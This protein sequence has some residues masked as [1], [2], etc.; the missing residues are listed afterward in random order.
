VV[1]IGLF[2]EFSYP[3][4]TEHQMYREVMEQIVLADDLGYD[5]FSTTQSF[6]K[7]EVSCSSF[8]LGLYV[9]MAQRTRQIRFLTGVTTVPLHIPTVLASEIA[10][11][12]LLTN[13][14][15]EIGLG[16]GHPWV[17][18]RAGIDL[19]ESRPR[20]EEGI[21]A[22][23]Q[24]FES[25]YVERFEGRFWRFTKFAVSPDPI[26]RPHPPFYV[27][28]SISPASS[29]FAGS[30]GQGLLVPAYIGIPLD[31]V[32]GLIAGYRKNVP[33]GK[34]E[35]VVLG[36]HVFVAKNHEEATRNGAQG[37]ASQAKTFLDCVAKHMDVL[38]EAYAGYR[39][40]IG[41]F[42]RLSN[43]K[44]ALRHVEDGAPNTLAV[45]GTPTECLE[46]IRFYLNEIKPQQLIIDIASGSLEQE[47][48][49]SSMRL[50]AREVMPELRKA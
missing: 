20:F 44:T 47:K 28:V 42:G 17:L 37:F 30:V 24:I 23:I 15:I 36:I 9:A 45:W 1:R 22:L 12:D 5:F 32:Q 38:G 27:A 10:A 29:A 18:P 7:D 16:R 41:I 19:Q 31:L 33:A 2:T 40:A 4:K 35:E 34:K 25:G 3:G 26:Q 6:G 21:R 11:T 43:P 14:R 46:R 48:V 50:F 8:P 49:L 39:D 13:G